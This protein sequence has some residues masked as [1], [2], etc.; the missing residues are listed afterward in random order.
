[1]R[2]FTGS[3]DTVQPPGMTADNNSTFRFSTEILVRLGEEL[4]PN[5]DQGILELV[6]NAYDADATYCKV[7]L[8]ETDAPGGTVI[9]TDDGSGMDGAAIRD[10]WLVLGRS[11]KA[12]I[13]KTRKG[14]RPAGSKGLGRLAALRLGQIAELLTWRSDAPKLAHRLLI[15]WA[16]FDR[17]RTV[18]DVALHIEDIPRP[19]EARGKSGT[20]LTLRDL[21]SKLTRNDVKRL[22]RALVLLADPF[23]D[24]PEAF[25]PTL[26]S[27]VFEDLSDLVDNKYFDAS[28]FHLRAWLDEHGEISAELSFKSAKGRETIRHSGE[29]VSPKGVTYRCPAVELEVWTFLLKPGLGDGNIGHRVNIERWLE[30]FGGVHIYENGLRVS[31]YGDP[32]NDWLDLNLQRAKNPEHRASTNNSIGRLQVTNPGRSLLQKTDR[33]GY[34]ETAAFDEI[35]R[36]AKDALNWMV[37]R[38]QELRKQERVAEKLIRA[39]DSEQARR[40]LESL[41]ASVEPKQRKEIEK[42]VQTY[43]RL[44]NQEAEELRKDLQLYR[45]LATAGIMSAVFYHDARVG[46]LR[47]IDTAVSSIDHRVK[48]Q[49]GPAIYEKSFRR[50]I[51]LVRQASESLSAIGDVTLGLLAHDKRRRARCDAHDVATK[52]VEKFR[53]YLAERLVEIRLRLVDGPAHV[54]ASAAAIES[55][56]ANLLSNSARALEDSPRKDKRIEILSGRSP[57]TLLLSVRDNGPGIVGIPLADIWLPGETTRPN[58]TGLGLTIVR[59]IVADLHGSVEVSPRGKIGGAEFRVEIPN[60]LAKK[61]S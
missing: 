19:P 25:R 47:T 37:R 57:D 12:T 24:S 54:L 50:D 42:A 56:L 55:I 35:K 26:V 59:D 27:D 29:D 45:T 31:P 41:V 51:G 52:L 7:E 49:L 18:E 21:R 23:T 22:A 44:R 20:R 15:E 1:M 6:K 34:I 9:L 3:C 43:E 8:L 10:A 60:D 13:E 30:N 36:F 40:E 61:V 4:N 2:R 39:A 46:P 58:G 5:P 38:R 17:A 11:A 14:R 28:D 48:K 33:S 16:R 53:P 32:G